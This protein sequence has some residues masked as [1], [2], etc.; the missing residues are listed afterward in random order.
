VLDQGYN[1]R[2]VTIGDNAMILSKCTVLAD[3]GEGAVIGANSVVTRPVPA[4]CLAAGVPARVLEYF[5]PP[6][7]SPPGLGG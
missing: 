3:I 4:F 5:G 1:F 2:P 6:D 7:Q